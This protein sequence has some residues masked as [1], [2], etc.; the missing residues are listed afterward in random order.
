MDQ[1]IFC[2]YFHCQTKHPT[3]RVIFLREGENTG[4]FWHASCGMSQWGPLC[5]S[6]LHFSSSAP[7]KKVPSYNPPNAC[8]SAALLPRVLSDWAVCLLAPPPWHPEW[9][10][11]PI[12]ACLD[13]ASVVVV[14][15]GVKNALDPSFGSQAPSVAPIWL[16]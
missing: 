5:G 16:Q 2:I 1:D 9:E 4:T 14:E 3:I 7:S 13:K 11:C 6:I 15:G 12:G 8:E 10:D